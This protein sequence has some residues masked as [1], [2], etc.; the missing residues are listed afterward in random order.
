MSV[1]VRSADAPL[2]SSS[3]RTASFARSTFVS[4]ERYILQIWDGLSVFLTGT[5]CAVVYTAVKQGQPGGVPVDNFIPIAMRISV[6]ACLL[7]AMVFQPV[8]ISRL[9][10]DWRALLVQVAF[11]TGILISLLLG[12]G[13]L[14]RALVFVPREWVVG[15]TV[16]IYVS[17]T[18]GRVVVSGVI[19][20][21]AP[22]ALLRPK[23]IVAGKRS[24]ADALILHLR[25]SSGN[26]TDIVRVFYDDEESESEGGYITDLI[27]YGK[28]HS[29]SQVLLALGEVTDA[30]WLEGVVGRLKALD[31][32]IALC[33][34]LIS[35]SNFELRL[36]S[37]GAV[38]LVLLATRPL[39]RRSL[40]IKAAE[41]KVLAALLLLAIFPLML[42][43]AIT[44]K[45]DS[46]GPVL[47]RQRRYGLNNVE[48]EIF[49]FRTMTSTKNDLG[50]GR[51]QT[52]RNDS[53]VTRVG[54]FLRRSSLDELP[55]LL[56]VLRGEMSLVG[57][58]PH[59]TVMRTEDRLGSEIIPDYPHRHRVKP[60]MTGWAQVN[61]YRGAT[62]TAEQVKRRVEHDIFYIENWSVFFDL[63]IIALT[64][65]TMIFNN[66]NAF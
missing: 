22:H 32:D 30:Q 51:W 46:E 52:Q 11:Q 42:M 8:R 50:D 14:T 17:V 1:N 48:F 35:A 7:A 3:L 18:A 61:G 5:L 28:R 24:I 36:G 29:V 49:K 62:R 9:G 25:G 64:P 26:A 6:V 59:P 55:Q 44:I 16:A 34:Y 40:L 60:G 43:I 57:P 2:P 37:L 63:K 39:G 54:H 45:L 65:I 23:V 15:W 13:F 66:E 41:D 27:A 33:P 47:F 19:N 10:S 58:R 53:R 4:I 56:N 21:A 31:V 12:I 20:Q 38:P